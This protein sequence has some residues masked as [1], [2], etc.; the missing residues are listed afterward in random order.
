MTSRAFWLIVTIGFIVMLASGASA[1]TKTKK[2][3][4]NVPVSGARTAGAASSCRGGNLFPCGPVYNGTDYLGSDPDPFIR[5]MI[6]RDLGAR[7]GG[8]S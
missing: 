1:A 3:R 8:E 4:H 2:T 7:Y 6:Q 5:L